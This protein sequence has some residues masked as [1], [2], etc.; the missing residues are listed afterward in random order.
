MNKQSLQEKLYSLQDKKYQS[1]QYKLIPTIDA[2]TIIGVR[3][4]D[5]RVLAKEMNKD[6]YVEEFINDLPHTYFEE[7]QIHSFLI[8]MQKDYDKTLVMIND[9]LPYIDNW[10]TCDQAT[11]VAL[12]KNPEKTI[13]EIKKWISIGNTYYI[14]YGI[15]VLL[16]LF[17]DDLF[18]EEYLQIVASVKSEE[19]YVEMMQGW[20]FATAL[21]KQYDAAIKYIENGL[22]DKIVNNITIKKAI[23]SYRITEVQKEYL[24]KYRIK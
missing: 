7:N 8:G 21:A 13:T 5:L 10:A 4:P 19:Y 2:N 24:R 9:F 17:L 6:K 11:P 20:Y 18:K 23:E 14:R 1:F 12:K 16:A 15:G 22:L 3:T